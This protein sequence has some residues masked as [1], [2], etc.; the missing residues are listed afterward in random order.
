MLRESLS[1]VP[2]LPP[3]AFIQEVEC[4][5]SSV[6]QETAQCIEIFLSLTINDSQVCFICIGMC[7]CVR[8]VVVMIVAVVIDIVRL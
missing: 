5:L 7:L 6:C 4:W 3:L 8:A 1:L 2:V